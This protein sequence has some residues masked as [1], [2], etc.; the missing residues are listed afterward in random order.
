VVQRKVAPKKAHDLINETVLGTFRSYG[1]QNPN[2]ITSHLSDLASRPFL[3]S[4][5]SS[6]HLQRS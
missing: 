6:L 5:P 1:A 4:L 3:Q 2:P